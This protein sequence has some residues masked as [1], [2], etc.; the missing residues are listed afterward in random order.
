MSDIDQPID[1]GATARRPAWGPFSGRQL[2]VMFCALMAAVVLLPSTVY[3]VDAF[4]NVA[5]EDPVTGVK[6]KVANNGAVKVGDAKGPL[7]VDGT[8]AEV[9]V[10]PASVWSVS[11]VVG[12]TFITTVAGP[13]ASGIELTSLSVASSAPATGFARLTLWWQVLPAEATECSNATDGRNYE[14]LIKDGAPFAV[15]FPTPLQLRP[16]AG[17][18]ICLVAMNYYPSGSYTLQLNASGYYG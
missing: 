3:A 13:S 9:P 1:A 2:T 4:T 15:A 16:P 5:V 6:A 12:D 14:I 8:V 11:T 18:Q 10:P 17:Q 7:T